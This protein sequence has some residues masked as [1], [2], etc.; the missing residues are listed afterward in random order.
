LEEVPPEA[1]TRHLVQAGLPR[2]F[3]EGLLARYAED[4]GAFRA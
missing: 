2:P 4:A 3:V 1:L